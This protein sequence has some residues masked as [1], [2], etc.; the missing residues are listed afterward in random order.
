M[1]NAQVLVAQLTASPVPEENRPGVD[2]VGELADSR[3]AVPFGTG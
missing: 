2:G 1:V 3:T